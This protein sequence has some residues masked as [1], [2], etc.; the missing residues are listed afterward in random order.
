VPPDVVT[1]H[2]PSGALKSERTFDMSV[3]S[4]D[5][6]FTWNSYHSHNLSLHLA[7]SGKDVGMD[8]IGH[9]ELAKRFRLE[10]YQFLATV[11]DSPAN[12]SVFP[13][14]VLHTGQFLQ[15]SAHLLFAP[16][17]G[18]QA[19]D[20][21]DAGATGNKFLLELGY[22]FRDLTLHF[23]PY[24]RQ[25]QEDTIKIAADGDVE[26]AEGAEDA[27]AFELIE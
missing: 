3:H 27:A 9:S 4:S 14:C 8:G 24:T 11:V 23:A 10:P 1:P 21:Y 16:S 2:A 15:L 18:R 17:C 13:T 7:Y 19:S 22:R 25:S 26:V 20:A 12:S 5:A 6:Q